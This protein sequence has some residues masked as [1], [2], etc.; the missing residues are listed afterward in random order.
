VINAHYMKGWVLFLVFLFVLSCGTESGKVSNTS[1]TS[2]DSAQDSSRYRYED[3]YE[4]NEDSEHE[5]KKSS[6]SKSSH[7]SGM[8]CMECHKEG[9]TGEGVFKVAGTVYDKNGQI[10]P[11]TTVKLYT[12]PNGSGELK[13]TLEVDK[14]GNFYTTENID[15]GQGLYPAVEGRGGV[16]YMPTSA[17]SGACNS[18]HD[19]NKRIWAE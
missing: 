17:S 3:R 1:T 8:N 7:N 15:F 13:Y 10:Y 2:D 6:Y 12:G 16:K 19:Q 14:S 18:C 4:E 9:G 11:G 5:L